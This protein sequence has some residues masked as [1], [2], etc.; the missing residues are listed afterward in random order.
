MTSRT[1]LAYLLNLIDANWQTDITGRR[2]S[3]P[4]P[5]LEMASAQ[6]VTRVSQYDSDVIFVRDGGPEGHTPKGVGW[7]HKGIESMATVD[8]R[9]QRGRPRLE[10]ARNAQNESERYGGL[11]GEVERILESVRRGDKEFDW[12][13]GYEWNDLSEEMGFQWY[14]GTWEVRLT[15]VATEINPEP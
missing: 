14:R 2:N 5:Y 15:Q 10:G 8:I 9:T 4:K 7:T 11:R 12:I 6:N 1:T 13:A 3:V